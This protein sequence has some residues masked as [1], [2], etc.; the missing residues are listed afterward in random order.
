MERA[1]PIVE[2]MPS[3]LIFVGNLQKHRPQLG[4]AVTSLFRLPA[5]AQAPKLRATAATGERK[6][7]LSRTEESQFQGSGGSIVEYGCLHDVTQRRRRQTR[8]EDAGQCRDT[9][10][11]RFSGDHLSSSARVLDLT[12]CC[13]TS[14]GRHGT[15][16]ATARG[17]NRG[18][19]LP[20]PAAEANV[21]CK[22]KGAQCNYPLSHKNRS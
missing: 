7:D 18:T 13:V 3:I 2:R 11:V 4:R 14:R 22:D 8:T 17:F 16:V 15:T 20:D 5:H 6:S 9:R 12:T 21:Q 19:G 10:H 1:R